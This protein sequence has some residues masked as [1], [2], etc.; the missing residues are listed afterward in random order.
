L[1]KDYLLSLDTA[2]SELAPDSGD[3]HIHDLARRV[4][5]LEKNC[6]DENK[7]L[8]PTPSAHLQKHSTEEAEEIEEPH[9]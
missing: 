8:N 6:P 5:E 4:R 9:H 2:L 3:V 1:N 7:A